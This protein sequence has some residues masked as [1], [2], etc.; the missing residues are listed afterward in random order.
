MSLSGFDLMVSIGPSVNMYD[1]RYLARS[2]QSSESRMDVQ[3]KCVS[4]FLY[5]RGITNILS[6]LHVLN[7]VIIVNGNCLIRKCS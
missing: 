7:L 1:L 5:S 6:A 2:V 3:L 4:S